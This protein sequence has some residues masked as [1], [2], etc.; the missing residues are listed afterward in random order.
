MRPMR[1]QLLTQLWKVSLFFTR[2]GQS[3]YFA[4]GVRVKVQ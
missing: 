1:R 4:R 3:L 2:E